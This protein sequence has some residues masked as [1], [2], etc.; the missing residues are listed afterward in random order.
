MI[1]C[2]KW[3]VPD[4]SDPKAMRDCFLRE[5]TILG[6]LADVPGVVHLEAPSTE[7][8]GT[9]AVYLR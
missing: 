6:E 2:K 4:G 7:H 3:V 1:A 9:P 8:N 5:A